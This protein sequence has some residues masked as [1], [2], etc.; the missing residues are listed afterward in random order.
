MLSES[1]SSDLWLPLCLSTESR[2][3]NVQIFMMPTFALPVT[4]CMCSVYQR[5]MENIY[6][7]SILLLSFINKKKSHPLEQGFSTFCKPGS[8]KDDSM[9]L[10]PQVLA[11]FILTFHPPECMRKTCRPGHL[12]QQQQ[13]QQQPAVLQDTGTAAIKATNASAF[14]TLPKEKLNK[15][16]KITE[17]H[18]RPYK[19]PLL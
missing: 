13:Q 9:Q 19:K 3:R 2:G 14:V 18:L 17:K 1:H 5:E 7:R 10:C 16:K 4:Y 6:T 12:A 15:G 11:R 8:P